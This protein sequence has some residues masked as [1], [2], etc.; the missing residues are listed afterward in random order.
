[1]GAI[2]RGEFVRIRW[3]VLDAAAVAALERP[4]FTLRD[5]TA[6]MEGQPTIWGL[7]TGQEVTLSGKDLRERAL[8]PEMRAE[9][10]RIQAIVDEAHAAAVAAWPR[11]REDDERAWEPF[12]AKDDQRHLLTADERDE[13]DAAEGWDT[14]FETS[15]ALADDAATQTWEGPGPGRWLVIVQNAGHCWA[16]LRGVEQVVASKIRFD[17]TRIALPGAEPITLAAPRYEDRSFDLIYPPSECRERQ[18]VVDRRQGLTTQPFT[19]SK[20]PETLGNGP[21]YRVG[22]L[23][24][25]GMRWLD[26]SP[27]DYSVTATPTT[28]LLRNRLELFRRELASRGIYYEDDAQ[29]TGYEL[30]WALPDGVVPFD[31]HEPHAPSAYTVSGEGR[32]EDDKYEQI[33]RLYDP[34]GDQEDLN[35]STDFGTPRMPAKVDVPAT[36]LLYSISG[37]VAGIVVGEEWTAAHLDV[38]GVAAGFNNGASTEPSLTAVDRDRAASVTEPPPIGWNAVDAADRVQRAAYVLATGGRPDAEIEAYLSRLRGPIVRALLARDA[39]R[40]A[41]DGDIDAAR[42]A[43]R[44][45]PPLAPGPFPLRAYAIIELAGRLAD[46]QRREN[47]V[48]EALTT[49]DDPLERRLALTTAGRA[50]EVLAPTLALAADIWGADQATAPLCDARIW[51]EQIAIPL[52]GAL[53]MPEAEPP[54]NEEEE[55]HGVPVAL[56][57][58]ARNSSASDFVEAWLAA[59]LEQRVDAGCWLLGRAVAT[60][61]FDIADALVGA[62]VAVSGSSRWIMDGLFDHAGRTPLASA[63]EAGSLTGTRW[64]IEHGAEPD[65]GQRSRGRTLAG[66]ETC[67]PIPA[68]VLAAQY[69]RAD[70]L[71][72]LLE[73]GGDPL[74]PVANGITPLVAAAYGGNV[75]CVDLL[76]SAGADAN[77]PA[78]EETVASEPPTAAALLYACDRGHDAVVRLLLDRGADPTVPR[79]DGGLALQLAMERCSLRTLEALIAAGADAAAVNRDGLSVLHTA[80]LKRRADALPLLLGAGATVDL[81]AG[82]GATVSTLR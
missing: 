28:A 18:A 3:R 13:L 82:D 78:G 46:E 39:L 16:A 38:S 63:I 35:W 27:G 64:C 44:I 52:S 54:T 48:C 68:V 51:E 37:A 12:P 75:E 36:R 45:L 17:L 6:L 70:I 9:L 15:A 72:W 4:D 67:F 1:M 34:E 76:L 20:G 62:G 5:V 53:E 80:M 59:D 81:R 11:N 23:D 77:Q 47:L 7:V 60:E 29:E 43:A 79:G 14:P 32:P 69:G 24:G 41:A 56:A 30:R 65:A 50:R 31:F 55:R 73:I 71:G 49:L 33:T 10:I 2:V 57:W 40:M 42:E 21:I 74:S 66:E 61:R 25:D 58:L 8:P 19:P 22:L 26:V